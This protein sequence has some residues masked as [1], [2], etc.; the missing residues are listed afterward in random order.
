MNY[1]F[2][3]M[4]L[5]GFSV[6]KRVLNRLSSVRMCYFFI[7]LC[8]RHLKYVVGGKSKI[9]IFTSGIKVG[10]RRYGIAF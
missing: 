2:F 1:I 9:V 3:E 6:R 10:I 5:L 8:F 7:S 4:Y